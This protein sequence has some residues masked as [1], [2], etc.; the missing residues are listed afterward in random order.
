[1]TR[2]VFCRIIGGPN[3]R[4]RA[5]DDVVV[6]ILDHLPLFLARPRRASTTRC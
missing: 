2:R 6:A 5:D 4:R 1:V 3:P